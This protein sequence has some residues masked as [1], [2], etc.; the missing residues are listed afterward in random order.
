MYVD[1]D[2]NK[3]SNSL[4]STFWQLLTRL[5]ISSSLC[6]LNTSSASTEALP[7]GCTCA[8]APNQQEAVYKAQPAFHQ[9]LHCASP[10]S[11]KGRRCDHSSSQRLVGDCIKSNGVAY[12]Q[13]T[14]NMHLLITM[15][16]HATRTNPTCQLLSS[17]DSSGT[18][19]TQC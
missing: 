7:A 10:M 18:P 12:H 4:A 5:T 6:C 11:L 1:A 9:T 2:N 17:C 16:I 19:T 15:N 14:D 3:A 13:L 8:P